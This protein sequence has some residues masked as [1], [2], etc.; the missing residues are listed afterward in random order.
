MKPAKVVPTMR[1]LCRPLRGGRGL[2][3]K[4]PLLSSRP[5]MVAP[6]AGGVD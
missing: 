6:C 2:K 5:Q 3:H 1:M 4:Y